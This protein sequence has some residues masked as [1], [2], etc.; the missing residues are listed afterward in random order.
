MKIWDFILGM[1]KHWC[2]YKNKQTKKTII[3]SFSWAHF[4]G[5]GIGREFFDSLW[6]PPWLPYWDVSSVLQCFWLQGGSGGHL[7]QLAALSRAHCSSQS[8]HSVLCP[9]QFWKCPRTKIPQLHQASS[10]CALL[11]SWRVMSTGTSHLVPAICH[12]LTVYPGPLL[13][14]TSLQV[15]ESWNQIPH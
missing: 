9:V 2:C 10:V 11:L 6:S 4:V 15:L 14:L 1:D 13:F 12:F 5:L 7:I 3:F 8:G